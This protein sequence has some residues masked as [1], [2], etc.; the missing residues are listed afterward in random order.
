VSTVV[1]DDGEAA[2]RYHERE[3]AD[4]L[5]A[6]EALRGAS[7]LS[8]QLTAAGVLPAGKRRLPKSESDDPPADY[9][10]EAIPERDPAYRLPAGTD[11]DEPTVEAI[12]AEMR[13]EMAIRLQQL[14]MSRA[15][16]AV[17]AS[18]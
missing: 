2:M 11:C 10:E 13:R 16:A 15:R 1:H 18:L 5:L 7:R 4:A 8:E 3:T 9:S 6:F 14:G 12:S 17:L